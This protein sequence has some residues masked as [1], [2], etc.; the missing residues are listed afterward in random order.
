MEAVIYMA[1][2]LSFETESPDTTKYSVRHESVYMCVCMCVLKI[3]F[4]KSLVIGKTDGQGMDAD[5]RN[6]L[7]GR[8]EK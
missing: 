3:L 6:R 5:S 1:L 7:S 8:N 2:K 4:G